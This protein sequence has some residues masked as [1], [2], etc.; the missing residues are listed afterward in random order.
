VRRNPMKERWREGGVAR[1]VSMMIPSP[2]MVEIVAHAGFDWVLLDCE[3]G[4]LS[5]ESVELMVMAAEATGITA[6]GRP[7]NASPEGILEV[8][9]RGVMGVQVPHIRTAAAA[10]EVVDAAKYHPQ[11]N[12]SLAAR[13]RPAGYGLSTLPTQFTEEANRETLICVQV[14]DAE[15]LESLDEIL[16]VPGIDV[17]FLGPSDLSQS[18]GFPGRTD[19]PEL[20]GAMRDA[21]ER[22]V[23]SGKVAGSAGDASAWH[24]C[25]ES[26]ATY[27]YTHVPTLIAGGSTPFLSRAPAE[28]LRARI[29]RTESVR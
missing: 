2:Q 20:R 23:S 13:T 19:H 26:G 25:L 16:E 10:R 24:A 21:F 29:T 1:G 3:H 17:V 6:L 11:G 9:E 4:T 8:L 15:G 18:L 14:E 27:L 5:P 28:H 22:I 7:R 12:R